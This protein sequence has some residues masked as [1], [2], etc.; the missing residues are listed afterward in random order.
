MLYS[1][2][3]LHLRTKWEKLAKETTLEA[4]KFYEKKIHTT[5]TVILSFRI[6]GGIL[7]FTG[8]LVVVVVDVEVVVAIVVL[9]VVVAAVVV[10]VVVI[11]TGLASVVV[12]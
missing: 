6:F 10:V 2:S 9:L 3:I 8:F 12:V 11:S 5:F 4:L 7:D 1:V